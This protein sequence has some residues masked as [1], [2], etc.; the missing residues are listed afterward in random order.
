MLDAVKRDL[1]TEHD[2]GNMASFIVQCVFYTS[3]FSGYLMPAT[4]WL[5]IG[6]LALFYFMEK[7]F[8]RNVYSMQK[9]LTI[10]TTQ[11]IYNM[12]FYAMVIGNLLSVGNSLAVIRYLRLSGG[13]DWTM[14][15]VEILYNI[16]ALG[17]GFLMNK[18]YKEDAVKRRML[19]RL[20][21]Q[22]QAFGE[23][24]SMVEEFDNKYKL[25]NPYFKAKKRQY[26][27]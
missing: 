23:F 19:Q 25:R 21:V 14:P 27:V 10:N 8:I 24:S 22:T 12:A 7:H 18:W 9:G 5:A 13:F 16:V 4:N 1:P 6:G 2:I 20:H 15:V 11:M 17:Y 26:T 3:F